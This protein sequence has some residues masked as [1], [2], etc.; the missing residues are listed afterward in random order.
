[1]HRLAQVVAGSSEKARL[2]EVGLFRCGLLG[3][4][5]FDQFDVFK[6]QAGGINKRL[7]QHVGKAR[8]QRQIAQE[9]DP[10]QKT[11]VVGLHQKHRDAGQCR[12]EKN[13]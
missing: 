4:E 7:M 10:D 3:L 13:R 5:R 6:A 12:R 9:R 11:Q 8:H 2:G 1:M